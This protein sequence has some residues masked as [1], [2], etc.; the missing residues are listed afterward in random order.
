M[1]CYIPG[2]DDT[3]QRQEGGHYIKQ[4][5]DTIQ[6]N[7]VVDTPGFYPG[8]IDLKLHFMSGVVKVRPQK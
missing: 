5:R 4:E 6:A 1:F 2:R 7:M 3:D 8:E